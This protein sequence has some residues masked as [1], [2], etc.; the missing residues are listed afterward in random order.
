[1]NENRAQKIKQ[2]KL[3]NSRRTRNEERNKTGEK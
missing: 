1:M 3:S 2:N